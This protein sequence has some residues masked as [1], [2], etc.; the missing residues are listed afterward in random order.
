MNDSVKAVMIMSTMAVIFD[1]IE[2]RY[3]DLSD[4]EDAVEMIGFNSKEFIELHPIKMIHAL[5]EKLA[6]IDLTEELLTRMVAKDE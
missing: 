3:V 2:K 4:F 1:I 6:D 5:S